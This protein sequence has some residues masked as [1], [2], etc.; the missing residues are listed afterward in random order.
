MRSPLQE[1]LNLHY[2]FRFDPRGLS[3]TDREALRRDAS[4]CLAK[5]A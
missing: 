4:A 5:L 1:L 2:R 3:Q